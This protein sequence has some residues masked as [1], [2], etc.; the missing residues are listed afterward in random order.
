[1][2][3]TRQCGRAGTKIKAPSR[4]NLCMSAASPVEARSVPCFSCDA[5]IMAERLAVKMSG[6][7]VTPSSDAAAA[8]YC[9]DEDDDGDSTLAG[10]TASV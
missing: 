3:W 2:G 8:S 10:F 5:D 1:M 6:D 9:S 4:G 7:A